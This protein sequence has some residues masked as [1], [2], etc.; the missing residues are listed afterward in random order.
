MFLAVL[1]SFGVAMLAPLF[2]RLAKG[3]SG[4]LLALLPLGLTVYFASFLPR[5]SGGQTRREV[6]PWLPALDISLS[7]TLDGLSLLFALLISGIGVLIVLYASSYL[8]EDKQLPRFYL[9]LLAFMAAMLGLVLSDNLITLFVFWELTSLTSYFLIGYKHT[10]EDSRKSALQALV[11]TGLGGLAMLAGFLMLGSIAGSYELSVILGQASVIQAHPL[12]VPTVVLILLGALTKSAQF[13][14]HFWLPNAM[15]APTPVS[16]Y[17]HSATM[18][19]AGIYLMARLSPTMSGTDVWFWILG[20]SGTLTLGVSA[21]LALKQTDLKRLLAYSTVAA[22]GILTMLLAVGSEAAVKAAVIFLLAHSLYKAALFM[23][24]GTVDHEAG[25]RDITKLSGLARVMPI[26]FGSALLA[27]FS[28]AGLPPLFGFIG[29]E[30]AY[31]GFLGSQTMLVVAVIANAVMFVVA[32]LVAV[33]PFLGKRPENEIYEAPFKMWLGPALLAVLSLALALFPQVLEPFTQASVRAILGNPYE[34]DLYLF[35]SSFTPALILS[36]VTIALGILL[37]LVWKPIYNVLMRLE[38]PLDW[39]PAKGYELLMDGIVWLAKVQT[40][41][42]QS[43]N[44][45]RHLM[46]LTGFTFGLLGFTLFW[47]LGLEPVVM[48]LQTLRFDVTLYEAV[49][50]LLVIMSAVTALLARSKLMAVTSLGVIGFSIALFY[51]IYGAPDLA[52]TQFL[53]ETL[54]VIVLVLVMIRLPELKA[55]EKTS[56]PGRLRDAL[57]A[58]S[59]GVLMSVMLL[60][61]LQ[62]P[63]DLTLSRYFE[64]ESVPS[65]FGR[66]IVNVIIVDFRALDTLGE[67]TVL[68]I[69]A[70]GVLALLRRRKSKVTPY[71]REKGSEEQ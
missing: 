53:V 13:P 23:A 8:K 39:G 7:F 60:V 41:F 36:I 17:L 34:F 71:E 27:G 61:V 3:A 29:K 33:K 6:I 24:A 32:F 44:L 49:L 25:S 68:A 12:F 22:L 30:L 45:R 43:A 66:N 67:I 69:A 35:P 56:K 70:L 50:A 11:V 57:I 37:T 14:F 28:L 47:R 10:Y 52:I 16:A 2:V 58:I 62:Y 51:V 55:K 64:A 9:F 40:Q 18:V 21:I 5:V 20:I 26:T 15:A 59:G 38:K 48:A 19:K 65:G 63:L 54:V 4:W 42:I 46:V 1:A 31:A